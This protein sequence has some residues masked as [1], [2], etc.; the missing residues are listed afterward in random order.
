MKK[1]ELGATFSTHNGRLDVYTDFLRNVFL[2]S[3]VSAF[4]CSR[5]EAF[6]AV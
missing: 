1:D 4:M 3:K 2:I 5:I 6:L